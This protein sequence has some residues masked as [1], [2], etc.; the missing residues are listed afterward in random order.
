M[1]ARRYEDLDAWRLSREL[2]DEIAAIVRAN[3]DS[4]DFDL[5]NQLRSASRSPCRNIAEGFGR[6][7]P[8]DFAQFLR[9]ARGSL[10]ELGELLRDARAAGWIDQATVQRLTLLRNRAAGAVTQLLRYLATAKPPGSSRPTQKR[11][12][13][14]TTRDPRTRQNPEPVEPKHPEPSTKNPEPPQR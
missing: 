8:R 3:S 11:D 6:F 7:Q 1:G 2:A 5:L 12:G 13:S 14:R 4:N 10:Y 9:I